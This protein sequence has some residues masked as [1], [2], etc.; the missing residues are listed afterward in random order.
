MQVRWTDSA[1]NDLRAIR[2]HISTD[3]E[4]FADIV[5]DRI[6]DRV[7]QL[8]NHPESGHVVQEYGRDDIRE[9]LLHSYRIIHQVLSDQIRVLTVVHG[10]TNLPPTAPTAG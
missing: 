1:I 8:E 4:K 5:I 10:A 3:S 2:D 6:F 7:V 9:I